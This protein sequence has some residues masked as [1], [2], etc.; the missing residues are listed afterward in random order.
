MQHRKALPDI[1]RLSIVAAVIMLAFALTRLISFPAQDISFQFLGILV[2]F[3]LDFNGVITILTAVLSAAGMEWLLQSHPQRKKLKYGWFAIRHWIVPILT[4]LV[5]GVALE[6]F[7]GSDLWLA[8]FILGSLLLIAVLIAEYIVLDF[9]SVFSPF[10]IIG[11]T[12]LSFVLFF[13]LTV[14][15]NTTNMRLYLRIP[16]L[17]LG[18]MMVISRTFYLRLGKWLPTWAL[19][20]SLILIE[21]AVGLHYLPVSPIQYGLALVGI[22]YALTSI[23]SGIKE[24]RRQWT[25]WTEPVGIL[26]V[27]FLVGLFWH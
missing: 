11:L 25:L 12:A 24:S 17:G 8:T 26:V 16:L 10:A 7:A 13:L 15:V 9:Q 6:N 4:A 27:L 19:V 22:G 20:V 3:S 18:A 14:S 21:V 2:E 1:N 5:I 23:I